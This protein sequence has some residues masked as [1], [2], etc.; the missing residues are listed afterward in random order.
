MVL[1]LALHFHILTEGINYVHDHP[2]ISDSSCFFPNTKKKSQMPC[3]Q[4]TAMVFWCFFEIS[5]Y[6]QQKVEEQTRN[7][8]CGILY[9][10][11]ELEELFPG[12][13]QLQ[14]TNW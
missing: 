1:T 8:I 13:S 11:V 7:T 5:I 4:T 10:N 3:T 12:N 9:L 6:V 2:I 14:N